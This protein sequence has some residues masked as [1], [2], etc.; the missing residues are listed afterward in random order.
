MMN[1]K[2]F[3]V[4]DLLKLRVEEGAR[5]TS[6]LALIDSLLLDKGVDIMSPELP[7]HYPDDS[8]PSFEDF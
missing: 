1:I 4:P 5:H 6:V 7:F 8:D 3:S 2:D